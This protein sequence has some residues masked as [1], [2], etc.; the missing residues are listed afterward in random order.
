MNS[1]GVLGDVSVPVEVPDSVDGGVEYD[2][3]SRFS[4][5][6]LRIPSECAI[7]RNVV[8]SNKTASTAPQARVRV[9]NPRFNAVAFGTSVCTI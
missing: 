6:V 4:S 2:A 3:D 8:F 7:R 9:V 1:P 5:V